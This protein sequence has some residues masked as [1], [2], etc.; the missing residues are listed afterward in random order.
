MAETF[1]MPVKVGASGEVTQNVTTVQ[2]GDGY[3]TKVANG[4]NGETSKW[5]VSKTGT[6]EDLQPFIDF[7]SRHKGAISFYWTPPLESKGLFT[8][9][10]WKSATHGAGVYTLT[11]TFERVYSAGSVDITEPPGLPI[12]K[13]NGRTPDNG[14]NLSLTA[15]NVNA[16]TA[17]TSAKAIEALKK[18]D[19]PFQQYALKGDIPSLEETNSKIATI[20]KNIAEI[21][22]DVTNLQEQL[23]DTNEFA[24]QTYNELETLAGNVHSLNDEVAENKQAI[25]KMVKTVNNQSPDEK[26]NIALELGVK[27]DDKKSSTSSVYSSSKVEE[28]A[29][30]KAEIDDSSETESKVLSSKKTKE[31][32]GEQF[33]ISSTPLFTTFWWS[34]RDNIPAG[35]V[36]ADGQELAINTYPEAAQAIEQSKVPIVANEVWLT[37]LTTRGCYVANSSDGHFR[38]PDYNGR[39]ADSL[40]ALF[41]RGDNGLIPNGQIQLDEFKAHN[42]KRLTWTG[43]SGGGTARTWGTNNQDNGTYTDYTENTGG[44]ETRPINVSGCWIIKLFGAVTNVGSAN[45]GQ[46]AS[47][48]ANLAGRVSALESWKNLQRFTIIYPDGGTEENPVNLTL[49]KQYILDNPFPNEQVI[50]IAE[51]YVNGKWGETGWIYAGGGMGVKASQ[52]EDNIVVQVGNAA[53]ASQP[54]NSGS[55]LQFTGNW[56]TPAPCRVKVWR[57]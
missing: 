46:L 34:S 26:G 33:A 30:T 1:N 31:L 55:P 12:Y 20:N 52:F 25:G 32:I 18:E 29:K 15:A 38:L 27:I 6:K 19:N 11:T 3:K 43:G 49:G 21:D 40:G 48:Y 17:G 24:Q 4:M 37:N 45:A 22:T 51:I 56:T 9:E 54:N 44:S 8:A 5:T 53:F 47:D 28:I 13:I 23:T 35:Y 14:G 10:G 57:V 16:D 39:Y 42:H 50:C 41:L 2:Y 7:L 36:A